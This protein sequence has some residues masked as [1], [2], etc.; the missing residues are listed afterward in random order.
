MFEKRKNHEVVKFIN[1]TSSVK[2][3]TVKRNFYDCNSVTRQ[4]PPLLIVA[5]YQP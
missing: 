3:F 4:T 2:K 1:A 5:N